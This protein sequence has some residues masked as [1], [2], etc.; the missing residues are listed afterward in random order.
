MALKD[1]PQNINYLNPSGFEL[2]IKRLPYT[3]YYCQELNLPGIVLPPIDV[4]NPFVKLNYSATA[5]EV[6][7]LDATFKVD[8]NMLNYI[9]IVN[10]IKGIGFPENFNQYRANKATHGAEALRS[11]GS[12][13]ITTNG[14][15]PNIDITLID[16]VPV[17]ISP[18]RLYTT[19]SN[20]TYI[21]ATASFSVRDFNLTNI[22]DCIPAAT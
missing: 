19:D 13:I 20:L 5:I 2:V 12:L 6:G 18:L 8:E 22:R 9:E 10:W 11:D 21:I 4:P 15:V 3:T 1:N 17:S 7:M 14:K 16:I